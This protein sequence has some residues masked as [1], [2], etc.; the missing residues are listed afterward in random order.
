MSNELSETMARLHE[1]LE[2]EEAG[3][4]QKSGQGCLFS[5]AGP[6]G[7][8]LIKSLVDALDVQAKEIERLSGGAKGE[9][10]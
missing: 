7:L 10:R 1:Q 9:G 3:L 2:R 6:V 8:T 5:E 4:K